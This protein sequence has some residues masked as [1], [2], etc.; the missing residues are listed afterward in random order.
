MNKEIERKF[1]VDIKWRDVL[2]HRSNVQHIEQGIIVQEKDYYTRVRYYSYSNN[3]QPHADLCSKIKSGTISKDE[4]ESD[5][6]V[7]HAKILL[8]RAIHIV[9]KKRVKYYDMVN[10]LGWDIDYYPEHELIVVE[11]ELPTEE[12]SIEIK[13]EWVGREVTYEKEYNNVSLGKF[14]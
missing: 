5:I 3:N 8:E 12:H 2:F 13:P 4:Y 1:L 10:R 7:D 9:H 6:N 14:R 11:V